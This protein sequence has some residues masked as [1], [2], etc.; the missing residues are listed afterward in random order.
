MSTS[1]P[2]QRMMKYLYTMLV[3]FFVYGFTF[4]APVNFEVEVSPNPLS[5][6]EFADVTVRAIDQNG[7][8][9]TTYTDGDIW[10]EVEWLDYM[11]PDLILPGW[12]IGFFEPAD[13][14]IKIFS[15]WLAIKKPGT[16]NLIVADVYDTSLQWSTE[17]TVLAEN[18]W[19]ASSEV[20]VV[21]PVAGSVETDS[22][23]TVIGSTTFP[24]TPIEIFIDDISVQE[25]ISDENGDFVLPLSGI[26]PWDHTL[27][28]NALD[29]ENTVVSTEGPIPFSYEPV[30]GALSVTLN[31]EPS[32]TVFVDELLTFTVTTSPSVT[33]VFIRLADGEE[34]P[35]EKVQAW[36]FRKQQSLSSAGDYPVHVRLLVNGNSSEY[37]D[38]DTVTVQSDL[39]QIIS[40]DYTSDDERTMVDL[41]WTYTWTIEYFKIKYG[42]DSSDLRLSLTTA[43]PEG[44]LI[45]AD[46]TQTYFAQVLPVDEQWVVIGDPSSVIT[47]PPATTSLC[48]DGQVEWSEACDDGNVINGDGCSSVC[49]IEASVCGNGRVESGEQCD[50][51]NVLNNDG[52]NSLCQIAAIVPV[53]GNGTLESGEQCDDGNVLNNDG[54]SSLC[55]IEVEPTCYPDGITLQTKKVND[56]YYIHWAS[57]P[58]AVEYIIYRADQAVASTEQMSAIGK[59]TDTMFQYPFDPYSEV[60]RWA[61]YAVE[62]VCPNEEQKPV[63]DVTAVKVW[64]EDRAM[65]IFFLALAVFMGWR[66]V[67]TSR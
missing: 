3:G 40:L 41:F 53:C 25:S 24:N 60:D 58:D 2:I 36:L 44:M 23:V 56:K 62:A 55:Q 4:A 35:M 57:V 16:Y 45:L 31:I 17:V 11:D 14:G 10:I 13:Q 66:F 52:C 7:N 21:S 19:P 38:L 61:R 27:K 37:D 43:T 20:S 26:E 22:L 28:V 9:D 8:V 51:G 6:N 15:K 12:G 30:W 48:G 46:S 5:V 65:I 1:R 63:G 50:D 49:T 32:T 33:S 39:K 29:L 59:T 42:T 54:C 18:S 64:P 67:R 47:M 34:L